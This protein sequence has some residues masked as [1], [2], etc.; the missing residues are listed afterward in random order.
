MKRFLV[1]LLLVGICAV[2]LFHCSKPTGPLSVS[3]SIAKNR[4]H[5]T[6]LKTKAKKSAVKIL[7]LSLSNDL[8]LKSGIDINKMRPCDAFN[9]LQKND[10]NVWEHLFDESP[11]V[12]FFKMNNIKIDTMDDRDKMD[13]YISE[14]GNF[15]ELVL[16]LYEN[17][18]SRIQLSKKWRSSGEKTIIS[19]DQ[20]KKPVLYIKENLRDKL[21]SYLHDDHLESFL[22]SVAVSTGEKQNAVISKLSEIGDHLSYGA[23]YK[24]L[25]Y[26]TLNAARTASEL[27]AAYVLISKLPRLDY[28]FLIVMKNRNKDPEIQ[29]VL[30]N[31]SNKILMAEKKTTFHLARNLNLYEV[32]R[33]IN[34]HPN[35]HP[36][37]QD[38]AT[39]PE[40]NP[41]VR[42][43]GEECDD[44]EMIEL[45]EKYCR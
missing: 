18:E 41:S 21:D 30:T 11:V 35:R 43:Y 12:I 17:F 13:F 20:A 45:C 10:E 3:S 40:Y 44:R 4:A 32:A 27:A 9:Y 19:E 6:E 28:S 31:I 23:S 38:L 26:E 24:N 36:T 2:L 25:V 16:D 8:I 34:N 15:P 29:K 37:V 5:T 1:I 7:P 14:V 39:N 22:M 33:R 42:V